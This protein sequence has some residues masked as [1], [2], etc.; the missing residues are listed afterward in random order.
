LIPFSNTI[1]IV[2]TNISDNFIAGVID[3]DGSFYVY[4]NSD[5]V[6]KTGFSITNDILSRPLLESIKAKL[7]GIGT[8]NEGKKNDLVYSVRGLDQI[9]NILIPFMNN[10]PLF[11]ERAL[12]YEVFKTVSLI[13]KNEKPLTL[14]SKLKIVDLAYNSNKKGKRRKLT[15]SEYLKLLHKLN[16]SVP[17]NSDF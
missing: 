11:S 12:H 17:F 10:N 3:G 13:L 8:I 14:E 16:S 6:I 7:S 9:N 1:S 2:N 4:F 15:K 5:G